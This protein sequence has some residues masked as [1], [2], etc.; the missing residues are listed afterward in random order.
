MYQENIIVNQAG[1]PLNFIVSK[2]V[3]LTDSETATFAAGLLY[4]GTTGDVVGT[5]TAA[6]ITSAVGFSAETM[7]RGYK[8]IVKDTSGTGLTYT[9]ISDGTDWILQGTPVKA[10]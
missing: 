10:V 7:L 2:A 4:V 5:P 6:Q 9:Y 8:A 1:I 3:A